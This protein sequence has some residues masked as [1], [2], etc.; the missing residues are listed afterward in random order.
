MKKFIVPENSIETLAIEQA[1]KRN[2]WL[3]IPEQMDIASLENL[4]IELGFGNELNICYWNNMY[5]NHPHVF[6]YADIILSEILEKGDMKS[7][8][9]LKSDEED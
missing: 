2:A 8:M 1:I 9:F 7:V 5:A 6:L 3:V 4:A